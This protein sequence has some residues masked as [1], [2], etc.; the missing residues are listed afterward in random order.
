M[1]LSIYII[2]VGEIVSVRRYLARPSCE[3]ASERRQA[4]HAAV[5]CGRPHY[6]TIDASCYISAGIMSPFPTRFTGDI[7]KVYTL[8]HS[9]L[10]SSH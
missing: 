4:T 7:K 1:A 9:E 3:V 5:R 8:R 10:R 6:P 2:Q